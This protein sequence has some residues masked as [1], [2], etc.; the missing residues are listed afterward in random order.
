MSLL[1]R[2]CYSRSANLSKGTVETEET[3]EIVMPLVVAIFHY[4]SET[5]FHSYIVLPF[6]V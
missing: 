2:F 6:L 3:Q 4:K 5:F 1:S